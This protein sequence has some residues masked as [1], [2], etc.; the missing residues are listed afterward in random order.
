VELRG[1]FPLSDLPIWSNPNTFSPEPYLDLVLEPG[2]SR[3]WS[4]RYLFVS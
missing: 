2:D 3:E 1:D 4:L